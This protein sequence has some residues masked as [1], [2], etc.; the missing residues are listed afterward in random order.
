MDR[1]HGHA[2]ISTGTQCCLAPSALLCLSE[3]LVLVS[4]DI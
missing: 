3:V 4:N 1:K 2:C